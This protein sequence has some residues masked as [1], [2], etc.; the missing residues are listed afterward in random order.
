METLQPAMSLTEMCEA[1]LDDR[2]ETP[3][4]ISDL[5]LVKPWL[6]SDRKSV[7]RLGIAAYFSSI[8]NQFEFIEI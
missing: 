4:K 6:G 3:L 7:Q 2:L 8:Q 1:R 5:S